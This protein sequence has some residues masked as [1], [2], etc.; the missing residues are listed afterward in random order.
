MLGGLQEHEADV[1]SDRASS[2]VRLSILGLRE[3]GEHHKKINQKCRDIG[4]PMGGNGCATYGEKSGFSQLR[5]ILS[6]YIIR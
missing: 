2:S 6:L 3:G 1:L 4:T 5:G